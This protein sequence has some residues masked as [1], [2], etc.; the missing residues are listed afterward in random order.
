MIHVTSVN[1][2]RAHTLKIEGREVLSAI[3]KRPQDGAVQ[4]GPLGLIGDEQA[5]LS[6]HGGLSKAVYAYPAEHYPFWQ[7][8]RAQARAA[9]WHTPLAPGSMGENLSLSG[10]LEEQMWVGDMLRLPHCTLAISEPRLP[11]FKFNAVMGFS[12]AAKMMMQSGYCGAYLTVI[13][14]GTV[15]AGDPITVVPGERQVNLRE[16][17]AA[18]RN[19]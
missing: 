19:R 7:T 14:T 11:C 16:L 17:F 1:L 9:D 8:V 3:G 4:V 15:R 10:L 13:E 12:Q 2:A 18:R 6:V 5:D